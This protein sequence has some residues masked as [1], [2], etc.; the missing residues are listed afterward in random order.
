MSAT[1]VAEEDKMA[2]VRFETTSATTG[3]PEK[4]STG[5]AASETGLQHVRATLKEERRILFKLDRVILPLTAL[6]YLS[7]YLDR[8]NL[9][10]AKLQGL[11]TGLLDS[12]DTKYSVVLC[13]ESDSIVVLPGIVCLPGYGSMQFST[14]LSKSSSCVV[15]RLPW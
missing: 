14:L 9:G 3:D 6:L 7:A 1:N 5:Y 13:S 8:G 15:F 4:A 10:N 2:E 12:N 11:F